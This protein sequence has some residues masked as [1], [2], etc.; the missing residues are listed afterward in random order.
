MKVDGNQEVLCSVNLDYHQL[1]V[2]DSEETPV[3]V[4]AAASGI[5]DSASS[6]QKNSSSPECLFT[7][8]FAFA[9]G[10]AK[11]LQL[12]D[13]SINDFSAQAAETFYNSWTTLRPSSQK[14]ITDRIIHFSTK[15]NKCCRVKPCCKKV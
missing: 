2:A 11:N 3:R 4:E 15:E 14:H 9:I 8:Q 1:E 5:D 10:K 7:Q 6:C 13:L 12:L